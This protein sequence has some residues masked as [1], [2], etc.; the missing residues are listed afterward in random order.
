MLDM[1]KV[2]EYV[3]N[4][5]VNVPD[6]DIEYRGFHIKAKRDFGSYPY[7]NVNTYKKGYVVVKDGCNPMPGA[8]WATSVIGA[9]VMIDSYI[10]AEGDARLFWEIHRAKQ[11][12]DEY[13]EV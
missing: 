10:E 6:I 2:P 11:G 3:S 8:T 5:L 4:G 9:R 12:L 1:K 7:S 13:T